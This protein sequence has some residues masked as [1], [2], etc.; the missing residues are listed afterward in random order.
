MPTGKFQHPADLPV[1]ER[2]QKHGFSRDCLPG[3]FAGPLRTAPVVLL[4]LSPGLD[5]NDPDHCAS[6]LGQIYYAEQRTGRHNLPTKSEHEA[7]YKWIK[8][9]V[10]Q[11]GIT[12][13]QASSKV[14]TLNIGA[15]KSRKFKDWGMLAAL[16]S[17]RVTLDW[18]QS[19]LFPEAEAGKRVVICL[20]SPRYWGLEAGTARGSLFAPN[21]L[22]TAIMRQKETSDRELRE[23]V[24]AAVKVFVR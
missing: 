11:F 14:A 19:V 15:Y 7:A 3:P 8:K 24:A 2:M 12:Y 10:R 16:P 20:R 9:I 1:L 22:R 5:D 21:C 4:F 13:E 18:A 17:S 6:E 23:R